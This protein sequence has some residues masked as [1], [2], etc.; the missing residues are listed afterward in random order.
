MYCLH[1]I[2]RLDIYHYLRIDLT[3]SRDNMER[4]GIIILKGVGP[5]FSLLSYPFMRY[6][7]GNRVRMVLGDSN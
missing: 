2:L 6:L 4:E 5:S 3:I 7:L 1:G